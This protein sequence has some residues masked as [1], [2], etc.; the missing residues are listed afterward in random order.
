MTTQA[1]TI[2]DVLVHQDDKGRF[3]LNDL[4]KAAG[5]EAKHSPNRFTRSENYQSLI[6]EL[7]PDLAFA[8]VESIRG[9]KTPGTYGCKEIV[10]AYA[11]WISAK[12]HVV[13]IRAYDALVTGT[14]PTP[15]N[16][17]R[18]THAT[19]QQREPLVNAV[20]RLVKVAQ[21]KGHP[22]TYDQAHSIINLKMG[23]SGIDDM[24]PEQIPQAM[25]LVGDLLERVVLSGE[26]LAKPDAPEQTPA[27]SHTFQH[28][29]LDQITSRFDVFFRNDPYWSKLSKM[30]MIVITSVA[31]NTLRGTL[32]D[33]DLCF[34]NSAMSHLTIPRAHPLDGLVG[35]VVDALEKQPLR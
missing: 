34:L 17:P 2:S 6:N 23:V 32:N 29:P 13:V 7:T 15:T 22:I 11:M 19:K 14:Q 5:G 8:P 10:Y 27:P 12:F 21:S 35:R 20:R 9:G 31:W 26:Y 3:C 24:L 28:V 1:L 16:P 33:D 30:S 25:T 18:L 4:H